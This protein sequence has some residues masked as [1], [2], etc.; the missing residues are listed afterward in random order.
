VSR[1]LLKKKHRSQP[2]FFFLRL[3]ALEIDQRRNWPR[4]ILMKMLVRVSRRAPAPAPSGIH[5]RPQKPPSRSARH[6]GSLEGSRQRQAIRRIPAC[7]EAGV[8]RVAFHG[9]HKCNQLVPSPVMHAR[10]RMP[11]SKQALKVAV[12]RHNRYRRHL[13]Q[14][15]QPAAVPAASSYTNS[16]TPVRLL[17]NFDS[18]VSP[19]AVLWY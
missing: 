15:R 16:Y 5:H 11:L 3:G 14:P 7:N 9:L 6:Q 19:C 17:R 18:R 2:D 4:S 12:T 13:A 8:V 1:W 10:Q